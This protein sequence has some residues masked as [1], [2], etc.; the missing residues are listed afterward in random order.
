MFCISLLLGC[1]LCWKKSDICTAIPT[2]FTSTISA[3]A[4][5]ATPAQEPNFTSEVAGSRP[6]HEEL[7]WETI[8]YPSTFT[9]PTPSESERFSQ[10]FSNPTKPASDEYEQA[11]SYFSLR[12]FSSPL[13]TAPLYKPIHPSRASL[14]SLPK[15]GMLTKTC[16]TMQRRCTVA[17]YSGSSNER[18]RLTRFS[19]NSQLIPD[20]PIPLAPLSYG[21]NASCNPQFSK[22]CLH[23]TAA[24]SLE[25]QTLTVTVLNLTGSPQRLEDLTVLGSLP[26]LHSCPTPATTQSSFSPESNTLVLILK[27]CS[28][29]ELKNCELRLAPYVKKDQSQRGIG[30][31]EVVVKCGE[32]DWSSEHPMHFMKELSQNK[33]HDEKVPMSVF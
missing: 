23:F 13:Q 31:G 9:S 14:P 3:S 12:R 32:R 28:L 24:F 1:F 33:V 8:E 30:L 6:V 26:P 15:L 20:K 16:K 5:T 10:G 11:T 22:P 2:L 27:V 29:K 18:S 19:Y 21:S 17:G 25:Q 4:E 7:D